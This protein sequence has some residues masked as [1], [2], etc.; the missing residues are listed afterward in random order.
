MKD[1]RVAASKILT[2]P[3][4]R[5]FEGDRKQFIEDIR[6]ALYASKIISLRAGLSC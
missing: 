4:G 5:R 1:E 3:E 6:Q 2:G